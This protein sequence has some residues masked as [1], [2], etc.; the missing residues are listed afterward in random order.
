[1]E[2]NKENNKIKEYTDEEL[3]DR[4]ADVE[5]FYNKWGKNAIEILIEKERIFLGDKASSLEEMWF[6]RGTI[7]GLK[8]FK[9]WMENKTNQSLSR[10]DKEEEEPELGK[11]FE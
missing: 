11:E 2:E 3:K 1:M 9:E 10:H 8:A 7:N 5:L 4:A 6:S